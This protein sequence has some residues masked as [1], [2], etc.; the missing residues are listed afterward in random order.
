MP[1]SQRTIALI[2]IPTLAIPLA[3]SSTIIGLLAENVKNV[4][5]TLDQV[6]EAGFKGYLNVDT[7]GL[8]GIEIFTSL[9]LLLLSVVSTLRAFR[10]IEVTKSKGVHAVQGTVVLF[11]TLAWLG[12]MIAY[13]VITGDRILSVSKGPNF[14][15]INTELVELLINSLLGTN[16][17]DVGSTNSTASS[18]A[19]VSGASASSTS[20]GLNLNSIIA[21]IGS[22]LNQPTATSTATSSADGLQSLLNGAGSLFNPIPTKA[23]TSTQSSTED[24]LQSLLDGIGSFFNPSV[25]TSSQGGVLT[26][27]AVDAAVSPTVEVARRLLPT[28]TQELLPSAA[29]TMTK[30]L[31]AGFTSI[32]FYP[33]PTPAAPRLASAV[34][35]NLQVLIS[36]RSVEKVRRDLLGDL[37]AGLASSLNSLTESLTNGDLFI[38]LVNAYLRGNYRYV[39]LKQYSDVRAVGWT[40]FATLVLVSAV[41]LGLASSGESEPLSDEEEK[42]E[43]VEEDGASDAE[44]EDRRTWM[45]ERW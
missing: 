25:S 44:E 21:G 13:T 10:T 17:F 19:G 39:Q 30:S 45:R 41:L 28:K 3:F 1:M 34:G 42:K 8:L 31:L 26:A 16:V 5:H 36:A 7:N 11:L 12:G 37:G 27:R 2:T 32:P 24:G 43:R 20:G 9:I 15:N 33:T 4:L 18:S 35:N 23:I 22:I 29:T 40:T 6:D 38:Q 14:S